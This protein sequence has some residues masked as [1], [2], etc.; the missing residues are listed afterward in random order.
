[1][2]QVN[3]YILAVLISHK[4]YNLQ[5]TNERAFKKYNG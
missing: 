5:I 4:K 3:F 2:Q 1:M